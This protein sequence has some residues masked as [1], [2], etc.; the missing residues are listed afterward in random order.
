[1]ATLFRWLL[2]VT[3]ALIFLIA[4]GIGLVY[5]LASQSLPDYSSTVETPGITTPVEIVRDHSN[6]PHILGENDPDVYFGLGY[7]HAQDRLWQMTML[8][9]TAQGRLSE[10]FGPRTVKIDR[11]IRRLD[12]YRLA[13][14][15]VASQDA[16]T[17]DALRSYAAGVN[18]RLAEINHRALGRGAPEMFIF[19]APV[20]P[21]LRPINSLIWVRLVSILPI[22]PACTR[23][24]S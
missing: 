7:A 24:A 17:L 22:T 23:M 15:S 8:R 13:Q 12:I 20:A 9:R 3:A 19:N 1:M 10:I 4:L 11:L 14:Q 18:A 2:R 6:V 5:F 16:E 21:W